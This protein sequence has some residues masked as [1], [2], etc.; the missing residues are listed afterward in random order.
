VACCQ[1]IEEKNNKNFAAIDTSGNEK[2]T[3]D[4]KGA[5]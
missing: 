3:F 1:Q 4:I 2:K 5:G